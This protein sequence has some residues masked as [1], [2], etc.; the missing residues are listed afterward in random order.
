MDSK[1]VDAINEQIN[2]EFY[3]SYIYLSMSA[4]LKSLNLNGFAHWL[5]IQVQEELAHAMKLFN[6]LED[7]NGKVILEAIEKPKSTWNSPL[8]AFQDAYEHEKIV[9]ARI[10]NLVDMALT[11]KDHA[12]NAHLQWF[13][14][15]QVEEES[16]FC[17]IVQQISL[18]EKSPGGFFLLDKEFSQ[19]VFTPIDT[20]NK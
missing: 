11:Q 6:F 18:A 7:R 17:T 1:M 5:E 12:T 14:S 19:R 20:N 9:T 13:I 2:F 4:Y 15:E 16:N 8:D 10:N 3:S